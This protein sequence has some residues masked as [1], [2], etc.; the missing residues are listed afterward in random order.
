MK[1]VKAGAL[2]LLVGGLA[3]AEPPE[4]GFLPEVAVRLPTRLDWEFVASNFGPE[5][6]R[7]PAD[8]ESARQRY[9]LFVPPGYK[10]NRAWPLVV[11]LSPG[12]APLGWRAWQKVCEDNDLFFCC[13]YGAGNNVA[14]PPDP[15]HGR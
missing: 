1:T 5:E 7:L 3:A 10:P 15:G 11:F 2:L 6:T 13:A 4:S 12:D 9:Q 14:H 8:Y